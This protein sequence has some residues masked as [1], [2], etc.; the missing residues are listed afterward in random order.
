[1]SYSPDLYQRVILD[2]N[3]NPKNYREMGDATHQSEGFNP[4]CGDHLTVYLKVGADEVIED[5]SF[6]GDGCAISKSSASMMTAYLRGKTIHQA[7]TAFSEFHR[8]VLGELDPASEETSLGRLTIF[9]GVREYP[10]RT[11]CASLC[12]HTVTAALKNEE[13]TT[14][15]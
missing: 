4:L 14:T 7:E 9:Q 1:M 13:S 10:S 3:K 6:K 5:V 12:W 11:K 15:E 8:M 2:H